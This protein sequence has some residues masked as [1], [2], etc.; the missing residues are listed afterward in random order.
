V[1]AMKIANA[2]TILLSMPFEAD[3]IPPWSFGGKP[4]NAFDI[5]LVRLETNDGLVGWGEAFS[6]GRDIA[7]KQTIDTRL[8][9]LILGRDATQISKIKHS[10]EFQLHNFGR[11]SG[12]EY[13]IAAIDIALWDLLG[14]ACGQPLYRLLGGA[15]A[16]ELEV[17]ASLMR[18]GNVNDVVNATGRAV[19]R[20]YRYIKL[21]EIGL[22]E[23]RAAVKACA[24]KAKVMIDVNCP[25]TVTEALAIAKEL[26]DLD[27]YWFEQPVWPPENYLGL[28]RVRQQGL[29]RIA[30]GENAG[31]LH[32]FM[33]M[34]SAGAIDIA[35]PDVAKT[36]GLTEVLKIAALREAHGVEFVPHCA[37]FGPGQVATIH[38]SA[39]HRSTPIFERL[40]CDFEIELYGDATIP[41]NGKIKVPTGPGLGLEP[42]PEA[43][44]KFRLSV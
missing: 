8:L 16:E 43:L 18:Y 17:Y 23:I 3:G 4:A 38:L 14:K 27:L 31:S 25:W 19:D 32:D 12:V 36:G 24:G 5:L 42:V 37:L 40:F 9:P 20:G 21:H 29:Q 33:S 10:L 41:K 26:Q 6:R 11:I 28:A 44:E 22:D 2:K 30:A 35:Q 7:L 1:I 15:Y 34:I 13:G 39:A